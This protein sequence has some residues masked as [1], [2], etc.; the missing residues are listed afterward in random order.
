MNCPCYLSIYLSICLSIYLSIYPP[1]SIFALVTF[2]GL[3]SIL[4]DMSTATS[5]L[6]VIVEF[7]GIHAVRCGWSCRHLYGWGDRVSYSCRHCWGWEA[8]GVCTASPGATS[9]SGAASSAAVSRV[10]G[11]QAPPLLFPWF[12]LIYDFQ[13]THLY[14]YSCMEFSGVLVV[15][16]RVAF[17]ELWA[18]YW[19]Q[20]EGERQR[21]NFMPPSCQHLLFFFQ[22]LI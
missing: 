21:E 6:Y 22:L 9:F 15:L 14:M 11:L 8:R 10:S 2:F 20:I 16:D 18:F 17:F 13:S 12:C 5:V 4:S 7:M 1:I 3:K 19:L